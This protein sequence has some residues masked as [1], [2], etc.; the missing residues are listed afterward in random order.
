MIT[1]KIER[2]KDNNI[3]AF[4]AQGHAEYAPY[5]EDI[6][7]AAISAILQT[8]VFGLQEYL[9]LKPD[10]STDDGWLNCRLQSKLAC[11]QEVKAILETMLVGL[12]ETAK[13]YSD[14]IKIEE[15]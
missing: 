9:E 11:D 13:A 3:I 15:V 2:N 5:G 4:W 1:V 8:A 6:I 12:K 7:C 14:Y 10:V